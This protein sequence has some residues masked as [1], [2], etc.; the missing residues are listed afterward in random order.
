MAL[1]VDIKKKLP[2]FCLDVN[3]EAGTNTVGFLGASG[4]GKSMTLRCIAGIETPDSGIIELNGR[5]LFD[6]AKGI[7][8]PIRK[9]RVGFLFQNYALF[10]NMTVE[11]NIRFGLGSLSVSEQLKKVREMISVMHMEG[12]EK[13]YPSQLSGG[14]QQRAALARALVIDPEVLLL[15][16]PLSALDEHLRDNMLK[17]MIETLS[18]YRGVTLFVTH[19]IEEAY[20]VCRD[21]VVLSSGKLEA[22]GNKESVFMNPPTIETAHIT[23]CKNLSAAKLISSDEIEALDWGVILKVNKE[24]KKD[25]KYIGI[26]PYHIELAEDARDQNTINCWISYTGETPSRM[27]VYLSVGRKPSGNGEYQLQWEIP[28]EKWEKVKAMQQPLSLKLDPDKLIL[29]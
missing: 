19:N 2:G 23:G 28:R 21:L 29:I 6:S 11:E 26:R 14:Q 24:D 12:L 22:K 27:T 5:I 10:P 1:Y 8:L 17:Q 18:G 7:N 9:R 15:D 13:R 25:I 4:S 3:F 16:E 20:R